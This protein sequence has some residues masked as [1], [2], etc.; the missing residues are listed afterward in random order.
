MTVRD[1]IETFLQSPMK[2]EDNL[3][4]ASLELANFISWHSLARPLEE[5]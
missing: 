3:P 4:L 2:L 1:D 5:P